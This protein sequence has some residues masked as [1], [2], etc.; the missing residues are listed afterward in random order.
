MEGISRSPLLFL[1]LKGLRRNSGPGPRFA[2]CQALVQ[3]YPTAATQQKSTVADGSPP[4]DRVFFFPWMPSE[5]QE[6]PNESL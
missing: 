3:K 1:S 6:R 2:P 5:P 4:P